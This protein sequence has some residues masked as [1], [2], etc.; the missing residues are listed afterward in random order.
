MFKLDT[1][2]ESAVEDSFPG[3]VTNKSTYSSKGVFESGS[4]SSDG[5]EGAKPLI[6]WG[7]GSGMSS[8][9]G[10]VVLYIQMELCHMTLRDWLDRRNSQTGVD[11]RDNFRIFQQLLLAVAH[12]HQQGI[13]HRDIKVRS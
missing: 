10:Q 6:P 13:L 11:I 3:G 9:H 2:N 12:L 5:D 7:R 1:N 4:G 8:L